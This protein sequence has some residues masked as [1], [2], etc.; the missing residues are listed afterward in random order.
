MSKIWFVAALCLALS[1]A[2][3]ARADE[4]SHRAAILEFFK[5]TEIERLLQQGTDASLQAQ[6]QMNPGLAQYAP[7][8]KEFMAKHM[9]WKALQDDFVR[10]YMK[11]F[12]EAEIKQIIAFYKTD[13]GRKLVVELPKLMQQGMQL[14][15]TR[16][17][18]H[19]PELL[20]SLQAGAGKG[21]P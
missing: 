16:V 2:P 12:N 15:A 20:K 11:S 3:R 17:Q 18:Q 4:A 13:V 21:K 1:A 14:G 7:Q 5:L 10:I 9:S 8:L 6:I 19:M